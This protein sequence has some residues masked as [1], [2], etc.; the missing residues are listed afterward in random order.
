MFVRFF[1]G[2]TPG[3]ILLIAIIFLA[4]WIFA[5]IHPSELP[6]TDY[7]AGAM[8][9][10]E[11]LLFVSGKN[12][13]LNVAIA[14]LIAVAILFLLVN[15]NTTSFF[16]NERT[17]LPAL[18][19]TLVT[20]LFPEY[21]SLNPALPAALFLM[22][23]I[24]RIAE[25]YRKPGIANN[26]FDAGILISTGSLFYA[27]LIWFGLIIIIGIILIRTVT[28]HEIAIT[29]FGLLTPYFITFGVYYVMGRDLIALLTRMGG[30]LFLQTG[31]YLFPRVTIIALIFVS[32]LTLVSIAFLLSLL[33]SKKIK[34]RKTFSLLLWTF[35]ISVTAYFMLPSVSME[36]IWIAAIPV[37]YFLTHYFVFMKKRLIPDLLLAMFFLLIFLIQVSYYK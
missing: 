24:I 20:A 4:V 23:A 18:F 25:G 35:L 33:N 12:V 32:I 9:L 36:I 19:Y 22:L 13:L 10:Y 14:F 16:I 3:V 37:S 26:F 29:V 8:P 6:A 27:D 2:N 17:Y 34:A 11:L 30:N 28:L 7:G 15:F 21:K 31:G 5:F 1:K